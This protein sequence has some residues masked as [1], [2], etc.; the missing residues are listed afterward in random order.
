MD[1]FKSSSSK[2]LVDLLKNLKCSLMFTTYESGC[3]VIISA[4]DNKLVQIT[5]GFKKPMGIA[6]SKDKLALV[7][8]NELLVFSNNNDL[9]LKYPNKPDTYDS[10]YMPRISYYTGNLDLHDVGFGVSN[11]IYAVNTRFSC[12]S[13]IDSDFSFKPIWKPSFISN[14]LPEDRCHLNGMALLNGIPKYA[15]A[16]SQTDVSEGWREHITSSGVL[17]DTVE[18][19]IIL[20]GL[21]MPH[22]PRIINNQL[23][24]LQSAKGEVIKVDTIKKTYEVVARIPGILR[25][26]AEYGNYVFIGVSKPRESSKT[27]KKLPE[28]FKK[29]SAGIVVFYKPTWGYVG[30][31]KYSSTIN[32][33]FD[34]QVLPNLLRPNITNRE[35][36]FVQ[37]SI[38]AKNLSFWF[39]RPNIAKNKSKTTNNGNDK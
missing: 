17:I 6:I 24:L 10:L 4:K 23:Y 22:S 38:V 18:N 16:L 25:G 29:Q 1:K 31:I 33:I 5:R 14:L 3:V 32:E 19:K 8:L 11:E 20:E 2:F 7:T 37:D 13:K 35:S 9:A 12:I 21:G 27:F 30:E 34:V 28:E 39:K 15:T 26:M 36:T